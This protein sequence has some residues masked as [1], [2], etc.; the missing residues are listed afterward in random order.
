MDITTTGFRGGLSWFGASSV[1]LF[2]LGA[3]LIGRGCARG[4]VSKV[5]SRVRIPIGVLLA[6]LVESLARLRFLLGWVPKAEKPIVEERE[7]EVGLGER[8]EEREEE[9]ILD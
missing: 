9:D 5:G 6:P 4:V 7:A 1:L 8:E 2:S 3:S